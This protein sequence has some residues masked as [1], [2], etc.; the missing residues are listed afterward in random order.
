MMRILVDTNIVLDVLLHRA[1]FFEDSRRIWEV[2]DEGVFDACIA[3][4]T[5]P[6]RH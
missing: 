1:P 6:M 2:A 5:N 3:S 4:F